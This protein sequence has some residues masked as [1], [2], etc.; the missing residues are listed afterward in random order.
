M[1]THERENYIQ[2]FAN[3]KRIECLVHFTHISNLD[4]ILRKGLVPRKYLSEEAP[5]ARTNDQLRLDNHH[6]GNCLSISFPNYKMLFRYSNERRH[7]WAIISLKPEILWEYDCAF[8][9]KNA[10]CSSQREIPV[11]RLKENPALELM[12]EDDD[13][14]TRDRLRIPINYPTNPQAEVIVFGTIA[15]SAIS[16]I[17]FA[18][19]QS[20]QSWIQESQHGKASLFATTDRDFFAPRI[21]YEHWTSRQPP[22]TQTKHDQEIPF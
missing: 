6:D 1:Q 10:A 21:D 3:L 18:D 22:S 12:F 11:E 19:E 2:A 20:C 16:M 7:E 4:S 9:K 13:E 17:N 14:I 15:P 5:E 8:F